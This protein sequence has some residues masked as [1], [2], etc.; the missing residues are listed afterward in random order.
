MKRFTPGPRVKR[1]I[2]VSAVL[3]VIAGFAAIV[4]VSLLKVHKTV[5]SGSMEPTISVGSEVFVTPREHY[6]PGMIITFETE[7]KITTHR[8]VG[9]NSDGSFQTKGDANQFPDA[10]TPALTKDQVIG[11]VSA[12]IPYVGFL[13]TRDFWVARVQQPRFY[14]GIGSALLGITLVYFGL[15]QRERDKRTSQAK[16]ATPP[17]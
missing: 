5:L 6:T 8:L 11:E 15:W 1:L 10:W 4:L 7:G 12:T 13:T 2:G 9:F 3:V 17:A 14:I 16:P